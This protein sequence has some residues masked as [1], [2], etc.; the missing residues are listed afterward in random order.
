MFAARV[1]IQEATPAEPLYPSSARERVILLA[2]QVR[3]GQAAQARD[4]QR[5]REARAPRRAVSP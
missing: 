5:A 1:P 4:P 3:G 2:N